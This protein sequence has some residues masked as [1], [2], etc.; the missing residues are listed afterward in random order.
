MLC[1][2]EGLAEGFKI[3]KK[4][5]RSKCLWSQRREYGVLNE[6]KEGIVCDPDT[7]EIA[8]EEFA[9]LGQVTKS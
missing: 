3:K 8:R 5:L 7:K 1:W 4:I 6:G 9:G 2:T